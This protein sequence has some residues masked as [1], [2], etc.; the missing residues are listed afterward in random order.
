MKKYEKIKNK[1]IK[2]IIIGDTE[3]D[4]VSGKEFGLYSIAVEN[5]IRSKTMLKKCK[6]DMIISS[7]K[8]LNL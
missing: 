8:E 7:L 1:S 3:T 4:I 2:G 6:P 5:G